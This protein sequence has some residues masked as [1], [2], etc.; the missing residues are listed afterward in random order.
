M[1]NEEMLREF[2]S[3]PPEGKRVVTDL[4]A[5]LRQRYQ[6]VKEATAAVN[7]FVPDNAIGMWRDR[8]DMQ[9]STQWVRTA[10]KDEWGG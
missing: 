4:I 10:R 6:N 7:N 1:T 3:L 5:F 9:D 2:T 8:E